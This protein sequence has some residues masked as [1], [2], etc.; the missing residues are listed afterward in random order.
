[1]KPFNISNI[2]DSIKAS[3]DNGGFTIREAAEELHETGWLNYIDEE[4]AK[5]LLKINE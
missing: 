1:M 4:K 2:L 5:S 3:V